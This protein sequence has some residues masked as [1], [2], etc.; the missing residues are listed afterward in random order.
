MAMLEIKDLHVSIDGKPILKGVSL[1]VK[2]GE[3]HAL[4]GPNGS[5]KSTL[6]HAL[7]GHPRY[8]IDSGQVLFD[9]R[10]LLEMKPHERA[11]LGLFLAFQ[12]PMEIQGVG[13]AQFLFNAFRKNSKETSPAEFRKL[14]E[15]NLAVLDLDRAFVDRQLNVGFSGGEKKRAEILQMLML[16]PQ[17][18]V[19]DETD[20][21]LDI[22]SLK[23]VATAV[24]RMRSSMAALVITHY[25]R[26]L[27]Y[28][29]PDFVHVLVDGRIAVSG[30]AELAGELEHRGYGWLQE[31]G[32]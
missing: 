4:M 17:V 23:Y 31:N 2:K 7:L 24:D 16:K 1:S 26:I 29:R 20:S 15:E 21:G 13:L 18:A 32:N 14:L 11:Q 9:G 19:L 30:G 25:Q 8:R 28:L 6:S 3:V 27:N 10:N 12:Y 5:G 22:D